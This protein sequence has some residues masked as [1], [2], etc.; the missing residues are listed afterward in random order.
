MKRASRITRKNRRKSGGTGDCN[1]RFC[2][3][4]FVPKVKKMMAAITRMNAR[5]YPMNKSVTKPFDTAKSIKK[6]QKIYCNTDCKGT[7][8]EAGPNIAPSTFASVI[9]GLKTN[10]IKMKPKDIA[11]I[12]KTTTEMRNSIFKGKTNVLKDSFYEGL[13]AGEIKKLRKQGATSGCAIMTF[14]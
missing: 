14:V 1:T 3:K 9:E 2:E 11:N 8:F 10:N 4:Q 6:C 5:K 7:L 12:K 13:S